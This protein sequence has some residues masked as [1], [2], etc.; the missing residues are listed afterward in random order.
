V[1]SPAIPGM[2]RGDPGRLRQVLTNLVG[3]AVKFTE[4]GEVVIRVTSGA[5]RG[6]DDDQAHSLLA[7]HHSQLVTFE[8]RDTGIGIPVEARARLFQAFAQADGSTT[9]RYGG[10]GLGLTISRQL[11]ELMGGQIGLESDV[12]HGSTFWFTVPL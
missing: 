3:N 7:T 2:L 12:G 11:V 6:E 8:V 1:L 5:W 4:H 9:R 10:T